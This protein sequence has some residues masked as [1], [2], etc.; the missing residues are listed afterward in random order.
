MKST[1]LGVPVVAQW[2]KNP[3]SLHE[4]EGSIPGPA[5]WVKEVGHRCGLDTALQWL[6]LWCRLAATALIWSLAWELTYAADLPLKRKMN[7]QNS[8]VLHL[9][10]ADHNADGTGQTVRSTGWIAAPV[11]S[12]PQHLTG[13]AREEHPLVGSSLLHAL[14]SFSSVPSARTSWIAVELWQC[15]FLFLSFLGHSCGVWT[16]PDQGLYA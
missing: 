11:P 7:K 3:C 1:V 2:V 8:T 13:S 4:D 14:S 6:W 10:F 9:S 16:F 12:C 15:F 5:Q